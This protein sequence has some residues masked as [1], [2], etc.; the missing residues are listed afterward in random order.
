MSNPKRRKV[1]PIS[2]ASFRQI[3]NSRNKSTE[4][5]HYTYHF[6]KKETTALDTV[7]A[8]LFEQLTE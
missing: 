7:F 6:I 1:T 2:S 3:K 4:P 8:H 5:P